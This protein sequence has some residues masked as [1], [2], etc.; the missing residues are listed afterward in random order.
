MTDAFD[1]AGSLVDV[2]G[3]PS[4]QVV[5]RD[6]IVAAIQQRGDEM[7]AHESG[8][9][10]DQAAGHQVVLAGSS[11]PTVRAYSR[12]SILHTLPDPVDN[13]TVVLSPEAR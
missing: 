8:T 1:E 10:C 13:V 11:I 3:G 7:G 4:G 2:L 9:S 12:V 6:D 5:Q